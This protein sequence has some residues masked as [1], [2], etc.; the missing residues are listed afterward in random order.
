LT[1]YSVVSELIDKRDVISFFARVNWHSDSIYPKENLIASILE[2]QEYNDNY[3]IAPYFLLKKESEIVGIMLTIA[4]K[5]RISNFEEAI[6]IQGS[7]AYILPNHRGT[8]KLFI[9]ELENRYPE[10]FK[11]FIFSSNK[12]HSATLHYNYQK[13][14]SSIFNQNYYKLFRPLNFFK[15]SS[16]LKGLSRNYNL[17]IKD[18]NHSF[19]HIGF[20]SNWNYDFKRIDE[21]IQHQLHDKHYFQWTSKEVTQKTKKLLALSIDELF[22]DNQLFLFTQSN[23]ENELLGYALLKKIS[24]YHRLVLITFISV[25]NDI[26]ELLIKDVIDFCK[27]RKVDALVV[28]KSLIKQLPIGIF[29][30]IWLK[31]KAPLEVSIKIPNKYLNSF[32]LHKLSLFYHDDDMFF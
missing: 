5:I 32:S 17:E 22:E 8:F 21:F 12:V 14:D 28:N 30:P 31:K 16:K 26:S 3:G 2:Y 11:I 1:E 24:N 13:P 18:T 27:F 9:E 20:S 19:S 4:I 23:S 6:C 7:S 10:C 29:N 25:T 15:E